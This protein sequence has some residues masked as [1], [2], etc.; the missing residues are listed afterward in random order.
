MSATDLVRLAVEAAAKAGATSSDA[1]V[2]ENDGVTVLVRD[3]HTERVEQECSRG[4]GVRA[5][6]GTRLGL[7]YTNDLSEDAVRDAAMRAAALAEVAAE[8]EASGLPDAEDTGAFEGDLD[9]VDASAHSWTADTW[10]TRALRTEGAAREDERITMSEGARSGGG[11]S[12]MAL[13]RSTGFSG[14]REQSYCFS[15]SCRG[16]LPGRNP[17]I[18]TCLRISR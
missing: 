10:I 11:T 7:A 1:V 4:L 6:R 15:M 8:D 2:I 3:G 12:R 14:E 17:G 18:F 9:V 13:A 16:A 5:Y